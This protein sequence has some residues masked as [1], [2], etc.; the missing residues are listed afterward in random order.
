ML[1][2]FRHCLAG[3]EDSSQYLDKIETCI[4]TDGLKEA[5][6]DDV[7]DKDDRVEPY[8]L[9]EIVNKLSC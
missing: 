5:L 2:V 8:Q 1:K 9:F 4:F 7:R 6:F 3:E